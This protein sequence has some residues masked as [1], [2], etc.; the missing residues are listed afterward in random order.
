MS[1]QTLERTELDL[2]TGKGRVAHLV[3]PAGDGSKSGPTLIVEARVFGIPVEALC[4]HV[5][6]PS[7]DPRGLPLCRACKEI[8]DQRFRSD[9]KWSEA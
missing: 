4:G 7:R 9:E 8:W 6:V 2:S 1:T 5:W 3:A